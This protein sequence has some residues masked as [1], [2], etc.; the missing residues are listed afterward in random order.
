MTAT[1]AP[2]D[3]TTQEAL[4]AATMAVIATGELPSEDVPQR[5]LAAVTTDQ[6]LGWVAKELLVLGQM[7][8]PL[9]D[10]DDAAAK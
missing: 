2:L 8:C 1:I 7:T 10:D 9:G 3:Q 5:G 4:A 6:D